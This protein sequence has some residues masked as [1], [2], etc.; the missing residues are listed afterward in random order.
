MPQPIP[1]E[2]R[3]PF[4]ALL[5]AWSL[6][7]VVL[8]TAGFSSRWNY[9]YHFGLQNLVLEAPLTSL[10][11]HAFEIIR[12]PE[13]LWNLLNLF[14]LT[15]ILLVPFEIL[16]FV[17]TMA[18]DAIRERWKDRSAWRGKSRVGKIVTRLLTRHSGLV[19]DAIRAGIIVYIAFYV[20]E[21]A[22]NRR[23]WVNVVEGTSELPKITAIVHAGQSDAKGTAVLLPFTCE[24]SSDS[25]HFIRDPEI[26]RLLSAGVGCS[27]TDRSWRLLFRDD[28]FVYLFATLPGKD[29]RH[30]ETLVLPSSNELILAMQGASGGSSGIPN[31]QSRRGGSSSLRS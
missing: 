30:P 23:Y 18:V 22:A 3:S 16:R 13:I 24:K 28:K 7:V 29:C 8:T 21:S 17:A 9:Y 10:P 4:K 5:A 2:D 20:G 12:C 31:Q 1:A 25:P 26:V 15:V 14:R 11:A 27:S 6:V 19:I